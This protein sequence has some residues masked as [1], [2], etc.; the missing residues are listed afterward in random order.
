MNKLIFES[1]L[2]LLACQWRMAISPLHAL[3]R[4]V[5]SAAVGAS[6]PAHFYSAEEICRA[7]DLACVFYPTRVFCLQR[8]AATALLLRRHGLAAEMVIGAQILP[9]R[10]HAWVEIDGRIVND[11]PYM[12]AIYQVLER[13]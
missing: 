11:K 7:V 8:S 5:R 3:H 9:F 1:F 2:L 12:H 4:K 13:C 10:S 6:R